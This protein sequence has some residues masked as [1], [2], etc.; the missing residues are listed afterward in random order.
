MYRQA[1]LNSKPS[2]FF[3]PN[4][5]STDGTASLSTYSFSK[6][7]NQFAYGISQSGSDWVSI[8]NK[9]VDGVVVDKPVEWAKFTGIQ[10]THD[11][12]GYFYT[13]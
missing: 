1:T 10:W 13:R 3:D 7:G 2:V 4:L 11:E 9:Q 6:H 8:Y 12:Q 5:L